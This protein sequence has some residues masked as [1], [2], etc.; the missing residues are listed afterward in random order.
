MCDSLREIYQ[1][2]CRRSTPVAQTELNGPTTYCRAIWAMG[3]WIPTSA[4]T[5]LYTELAS[6]TSEGILF[7][8]SE[9]SG[10]LHW[11][12]FQLETFPVEPR[13]IDCSEGE[14]LKRI[15]YEFPPI[16]LNFV[17]ISKTRFGL[18]LCGYPNFDVNRIRNRIRHTLPAI[19]EPHPQDICHATLFRFTQPPSAAAL[20]LIDDLCIRYANEPLFRFNL[21]YW[22]YG[23]GSWL[24]K[25]RRVL[26]RW[27]SPPRWILHRG[28]KS[29]PDRTLENQE[30]LIKERLNEGWDVEI[31]VWKD[32]SGQFWL[33]HDGPTVR[34]QDGG[35]LQHPHVWVHCKNLEALVSM[36]VAANYFFHNVDDATLTSQRYIWCYPGH[37][38]GGGRDVIV[39]PE[40]SGIHFPQLS[41]AYAVCSDFAPSH[42]L[43]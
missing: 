43:S 5:S 21:A 13:S 24:Q 42:F 36:P 22:E 20:R 12:L 19:R 6:L 37:Q 29:G 7:D 1:T 25:E 23:Y 15:L 8:T 30:F 28:L 27:P 34:L 26:M 17:G 38:P 9:A 39:L 11:T 33:G 16:N 31:D 18:F 35:L 2:I 10:V 32:V 40:R 41:S 3:E 4:A 14:T